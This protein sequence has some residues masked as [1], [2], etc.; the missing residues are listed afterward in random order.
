MIGVVAALANIFGLS[1]FTHRFL[2]REDLDP[3]ERFGLSILIAMGVFGWLLFL[4]Q[5]IMPIGVWV[6]APGLALLGFELFQNRAQLPKFKSTPL[7]LVFAPGMLI[8]TVAALAPAD[9]M[10]WD[11]LAYHLAVPKLWLEAGKAIYIPYIHHSNFPFAFEMLYSPALSIGSEPGAKIHTVLALFAGILTLFGLG[12]R[13]F[14]GMAGWLTAAAFACCP[15]ILWQAGTG[16]IDLPHGLYAGLGIV[17]AGHFLARK[18]PGYLQLSGLMLGLACSTKYTG[19]QFVFVAA[20]VLAVAG[21]LRDRNGKLIGKSIA[22]VVASLVMMSPWLIRN[23]INTGNPLY[24][25][26]YERLGGRNWTQWHADIYRNE[27]QTF[28]VGRTE[29]GRDKLALGHA[30]LGLGYQPGRFI[31]PNQEQGG[32]FPM[33]ALGGAI[34]GV[35]ILGALFGKPERTVRFGLMCLLLIFLAWFVLSQQVRYMS[36]AI[37]ILALCAGSMADR[38]KLAIGAAVLVGA[39]SLYSWVLLYQTQTQRQLPVALGAQSRDAFLAQTTPFAAIA[40]DI[41]TEAKGGKIALYEEVFGYY[42]NVPYIWAN[43]GHSTLIDTT[44]MKTGAELVARLK[45]LGIT[46]VYLNMRLLAPVERVSYA[47]GSLAF[48]PDQVDHMMQDRNRQWLALLG[49]ASRQ[50]L[51]T[52]VKD[53]GGTSQRPPGSVLWKIN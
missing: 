13:I 27:Q 52:A 22:V 17:Y 10:E 23:V 44:Q 37:P 41:D 35:G 38:R 33:G 51:F 3:A 16:Y 36:A 6:Y 18:L 48:T 47:S 20:L 24:P 46:H 25:F 26:F 53:W 28:G 29:N 34:L 50:G 12:R 39:Q 40:H 9:V 21:V 1:L 4:L 19:L 15:L 43:P 45:E 42:L 30:V 49:D 14:G 7:S 11:S 31:N 5:L 8:G 2:N 32:G